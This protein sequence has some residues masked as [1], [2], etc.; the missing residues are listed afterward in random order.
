MTTE[1]TMPYHEFEPYGKYCVRCGADD[2]HPSHHKPLPQPATQPA[3]QPAPDTREWRVHKSK[4][5][6]VDERGFYVAFTTDEATAEQIVADHAAVPRLVAA[7]QKYVDAYAG[8]KSSHL[9]NGQARRSLDEFK[10]LLA[11]LRRSG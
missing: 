11:T 6:I 5:E 7:I 8:N 3:T 2:T 1:T 9:G 4:R 10:E